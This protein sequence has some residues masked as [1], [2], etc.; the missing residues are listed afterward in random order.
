MPSHPEN[1][2]PCDRPGARRHLQD[3]GPRSAPWATGRPGGPARLPAFRDCPPRPHGP[4]GFP[5]L[6]LRWG[7]RAGRPQEAGSVC[8]GHGGDH[9]PPMWAGPHGGGRRRTGHP[10]GPLIPA[11]HLVAL[12]TQLLQ[13][14]T[15]HLPRPAPPQQAKPPAACYS[16]PRYLGTV[17]HRLSPGTTAGS[18]FPVKAPR[19]DT[20]GHTGT[21]TARH[22][23]IPQHPRPPPFSCLGNPGPSCL[24][25]PDCR[26]WPGSR[27]R[28]S[29]HEPCSPSPGHAS[30]PGTPG[31]PAPGPAAVRT[32]PLTAPEPRGGH[33]P[34]HAGETLR[35]WASGPSAWGRRG[36]AAPRAWSLVSPVSSASSSPSSSSPEDGASVRQARGR[37]GERPAARQG[38][39]WAGLPHASPHREHRALTTTC[40]A[41]A[42][43]AQHPLG[44]ALAAAVGPG[45]LVGGVE[46]L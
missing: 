42:E 22:P 10:L 33:P 39:H 37:C 32:P 43:E 23:E 21:Q 13:K 38:P 30:R 7:G 26:P 18:P 34:P 3:P 29:D 24:P 28:G 6:G 20:H 5:P 41:H 15:A 25:E 45:V 19:P 1:P 31:A 35:G 16:R 2:E 14:R 8:C 44:E 40:H 27:S 11:L 9:R 4:A 36:W 12:Q 17:T 46:H